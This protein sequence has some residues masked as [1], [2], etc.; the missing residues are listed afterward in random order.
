MKIIRNLVT[1]SC[2]KRFLLGYKCGRCGFRQYTEHVRN[3]E[4]LCVHCFGV[5]YIYR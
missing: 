2:I 4:A 3:G 5:L 1:E